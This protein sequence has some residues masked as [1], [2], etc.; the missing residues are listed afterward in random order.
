MIVTD[1]IKEWLQWV[2]RTAIPL[3][4]TN[5]DGKP[6]GFASG[7]LVN[8]NGRKL[9]LSVSHAI[10]KGRWVAR[11]QYDP[12]VDQDSVHFF[13]Q[14]WALQPIGERDSG[15][16]ELDFSFTEVP[17]NFFSMM[18]ERN[19]AGKIVKQTLRHE[20]LTSLEDVP[21]ADEIYAFTGCVR[22]ARL[23]ETTYWSEPTIYP[24]LKYRRTEGGYH[25]FELPVPHPGHESF[26]GCSGAPIV[27]SQHRI[28]ALVCSGNDDSNTIRGI[29]LH[30]IS[31]AIRAFLRARP[32]DGRPPGQIT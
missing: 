8:I 7:C 30:H 9:V 26:Q 31:P 32:I 25:V 10:Q 17:A 27:D 1:E 6:V 21:V 29:S 13:G 24:G 5:D 16:D 18:E 12:A 4:R 19:S 2:G 11:V 3:V 14:Q 20:F 15:G 22:P 23:D 28:V